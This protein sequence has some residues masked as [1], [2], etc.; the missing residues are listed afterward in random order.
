MSRTSHFKIQFTKI[1]YFLAVAV[2]ALCGASI[3]ISIYRIVTFGI[4]GFTDVLK[5]PFLIF[6]S[7][8]CLVIV[9]SL[10]I[11]S[12]YIIDKKYLTVQYGLVKSKFELKSITSM[13]LDMT[14]NKLTVYMG[15]QFT[16]LSTSKDWN[17]E[18]VRAILAEN[19]SV[20]YSF[21]FSDEKHD[22]K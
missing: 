9:I 11:K 14:T 19:P 18:F 5:Y 3:A 4:T 13:V 8:F 6:V 16:V 17:E 10:L 12:Q 20:D 21:A 22:K 15:E 7:V 1:M 2:F